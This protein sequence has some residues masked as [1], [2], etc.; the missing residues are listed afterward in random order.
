VDVEAEDSLACEVVSESGMQLSVSLC[1]FS[2]AGDPELVLEPISL[3]GIAAGG[4]DGWAE[5]SGTQEGTATD[6]IGR[7]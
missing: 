7:N 6:A 4:V 3:M 1:A 5:D 2:S